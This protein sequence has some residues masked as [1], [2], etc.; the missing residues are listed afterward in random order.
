MEKIMKK[1]KV[2]RPP[3]EIKPKK[4]RTVYIS[5][6]VYSFYKKLGEGNFSKGIMINFKNAKKAA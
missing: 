1:N 3:L 2:G 5:D 4:I 6:R